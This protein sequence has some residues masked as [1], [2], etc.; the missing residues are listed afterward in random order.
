[1]A[2]RKRV[3]TVGS[4]VP[5]RRDFLRRGLGVSAL[6]AAGPLLEARGVE[7]P[8]SPRRTL[9]RNGLVVDGT[10]KAGFV[11]DVLIEGEHIKEVS[12]KPIDVACE[13]IDCTGKVISPGFVDVHSHMDWLLAVPKHPELKMP[14]TAQGCTSFVGGNCGFSP[15]GLRKD[16]AYIDLISM[17][18]GR[19]FEL[20]WGTMDGFF[21]HLRET[22]MSHN[23]LNLVGHG[24]TR[25]SIRGMDPSPLGKEEM[26]EMLALLEEAMDQGACGVSLGLQ[27]APGI[28][29]PPEEVLEVARL[30]KKKERVLTV[31]GRAYSALSGA[32][33]VK[34]LG[35]PH[36]VLSLEEM[37]GVARETG[38]RLQYSHLMFA[39]TAS[40]HTCAQCLDILDKAIAEGLDVKIDTYPYHC[41]QSVIN[42]V[43]PPWFQEN[44][45][46]NF[47]DK[48][49]M[50]RVEMELTLMS[51]ALGFGYSD[52]QM[53]NARHAELNQ[54]NG[55]FL[56]EI[57][58]RL[59]VSPFQ[60]AMTISEKSEG[61]ARVLNHKYSDMAVIDALMKH[62]AC[63]FMS[64]ATPFPEGVQNPAAYG[65]FPLLLQYARDRKLLSVEEAVHKMTGANAERVG[66]K[67][68]GTLK[69]GMAA[70]VTV[71]DWKT[72]KDNNTVAD[73]DNAPT[74]IEAVFINGQQVKSGDILDDSIN[75]G[76][77]LKA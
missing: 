8:A 45:P 60:A 73:M 58:E 71:F 77:V 29:A 48:E 24:T 6:A 27:Y 67:D 69:A 50:Y 56:S 10:G 21:T 63:L 15:G 39:G 47:H 26:A 46:A 12:P 75:A 13:G 1:M 3:G 70:D 51:S 11:G 55:L 19:G 25:A 49:A 14:F 54:Y 66:I 57:A 16:S 74:G 44:L 31:H 61:R 40:H 28:F 38:V 18:T 64:D 43:L 35:T 20:D 65:S 36:N 23:L 5:T 72:V 62:P 17:G 68:R 37:I 22:G 30:V 34:F 76:V 33:E 4:A 41:G 59:G 32:Y 52:I 53:L 7:A 2:R 42:V 9:L